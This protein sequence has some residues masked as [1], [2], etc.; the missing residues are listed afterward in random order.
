LKRNAGMIVAFLANSAPFCEI[1]Y[2]HKIRP[3]ICGKRSAGRDI[4]CSNALGFPEIMFGNMEE[5][6]EEIGQVY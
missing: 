6:G 5:T 3:D 4:F 2:K 1:L